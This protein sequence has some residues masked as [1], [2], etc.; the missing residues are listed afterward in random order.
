M[1]LS[2]AEKDIGVCNKDITTSNTSHEDEEDQCGCS[3]HPHQGGGLVQLK[4]GP[5]RILGAVLGKIDT[6]DAH[7]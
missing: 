2:F 4:L 7:G 3:T 6:Q 1:F 5:S